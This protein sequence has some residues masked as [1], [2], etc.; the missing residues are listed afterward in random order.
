MT[1]RFNMDGSPLLQ[2]K[3]WGTFSKDLQGW[4]SD[5]SRP[6]G[7]QILAFYKFVVGE[8]LDLLVL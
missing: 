2:D 5:I 6:T 1:D 7:A 4:K 3:I 8:L